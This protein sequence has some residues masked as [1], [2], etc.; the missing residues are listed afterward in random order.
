MDEGCG[1]LKVMISQSLTCDALMIDIDSEVIRSAL[2]DPT[3]AAVAHFVESE[4]K[5]RCRQVRDLW[6]AIDVFS[7][8]ALFGQQWEGDVTVV[9]PFSPR[10]LSKVRP[11]SGPVCLCFFS[12]CFLFPLPGTLPS[13]RPSNH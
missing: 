13:A 5:H 9:M 11:Q 8:F 4:W 1:G 3:L 2:Q 6:P 10:Q 7:V 12:S